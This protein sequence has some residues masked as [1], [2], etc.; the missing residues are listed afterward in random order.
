MVL[1]TMLFIMTNK[2]G[3]KYFR[4]ENYIRKFNSGNAIND[5]IVI[6]DNLMIERDGA[7][8]EGAAGGKLI[9]VSS[10]GQQRSI[11]SIAVP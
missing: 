8:E 9:D 6:N 4:M 5:T 10:I 7:I 3:I 1:Q 11:G 2:D